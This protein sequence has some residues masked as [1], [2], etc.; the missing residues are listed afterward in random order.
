MAIGIACAGSGLP[1]AVHILEPLLQDGQEFVKQGTLIALGLVLQSETAAHLPQVTTFRERLVKIISEKKESVLSRMGAIFS[2]GIIDA[3]GRNS[4]VSMM[5]V[6]APPPPP[7][8]TPAR[9]RAP[10]TRTFI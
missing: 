8:R 6:G 5:C 1:E 10:L 3:G 7:A 4:S 9:A 2:L